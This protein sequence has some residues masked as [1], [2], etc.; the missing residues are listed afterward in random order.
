M[1]DRDRLAHDVPN[2]L[3]PDGSVFV[4]APSNYDRQWAREDAR[5]PSCR[6]PLGLAPAITLKHVRLQ[7]T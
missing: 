7:T 3:I 4:T 5:C 1:V 2:L 6:H